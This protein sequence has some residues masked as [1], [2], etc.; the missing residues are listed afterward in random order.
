MDDDFQLCVNLLAGAMERQT[1]KLVCVDFD[2][3]LVKV[4][5]SGKWHESAEKLAKLVRPF[6]LYLLPALLRKGVLV[7]IVTFSAQRHLIQHTL[8]AA[9]GPTIARQI[10][11]RSMDGSWSPTPIESAPRSWYRCSRKGK[12]EHILSVVTKVYLNSSVEI[13]PSEVVLIDDANLNIAHARMDGISAFDMDPKCKLNDAATTESQICSSLTEYFCGHRR[14]KESKEYD[15]LDDDDDDNS[16]KHLQRVSAAHPAR[17][18][19]RMS[20]AIAT[21]HAKNLAEMDFL[22]IQNGKS[23]SSSSLPFS[24]CSGDDTF[25]PYSDRKSS[26]KGLNMY[27]KEP[28]KRSFVGPNRVNH[29]SKL[30]SPPLS[31]RC[32][33]QVDCCIM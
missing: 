8:Q 12:L 9:F 33:P 25:I 13:R 20:P 22:C 11:I 21:L 18:Q 27:N 14:S 19:P 5:T 26:S 28:S 23:S 17:S 3:T 15:A 30:L 32:V 7:C 6:F 10:F 31:S 24:Q 4:H 29:S 2:R 1:V 16:S